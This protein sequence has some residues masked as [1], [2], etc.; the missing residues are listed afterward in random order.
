MLID[1]LHKIYKYEASLTKYSSPIAM[2]SG[3]VP[4]FW[5][6]F[7]SFYIGINLTD[8]AFRNNYMEGDLW[9]PGTVYHGAF[10]GYIPHE[11]NH[12]DQYDAMKY[13]PFKSQTRPEKNISL[14]PGTNSYIKY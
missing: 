10:Q 9:E 3:A 6:M 5:R 11:P 1:C 4:A 13:S 2:L 7:I 8:I 12:L 14:G